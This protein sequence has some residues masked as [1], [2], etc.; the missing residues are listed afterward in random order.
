MLGELTVKGGVGKIFEYV[1]PGATTLE[2]P[3]RG[4]ITNMGA[5]MGATTSLFGTDERSRWYL[6]AQGREELF[7]P[8]QPDPDAEYAETRAKLSVM[9]NALEME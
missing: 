2:V 4:T 5:E 8:Q 1:G 3:E 6:K 7:S 9:M